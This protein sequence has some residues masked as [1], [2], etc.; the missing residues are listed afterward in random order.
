MK[1]LI[2]LA[3]LFLILASHLA[4]AS[5]WDDYKANTIAKMI[6]YYSRVEAYK[7]SDYFYTPGM[8]FKTTVKYL[9]K[10]RIIKQDRSAYIKK[11]FFSWGMT[12][13][14]AKTF[15][16]EILIEENGIKYWLPI[17]N[18]LIPHL[19]KEIKINDNVNLFIVL[20]GAIKKD[21]VFLINEFKALSKT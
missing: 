20:G 6:D 13:E 1:R 16:S 9:G 3:V 11:L 10:T 5:G 18:V 15:D 12:A 19:N 17:Q 21:W 8:P 14:Q 7:S 2:G 4:C